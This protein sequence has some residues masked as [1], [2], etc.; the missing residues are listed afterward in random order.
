MHLWLCV[1][2]LAE[3]SS[4]PVALVAGQLVGLPR[5]VGQIK[6]GNDAKDDRGNAFEDE[7]PPPAA[8]SKPRYPQQIATEGRPHRKRKRMG[9]PKPPDAYRAMSGS[10]PVQ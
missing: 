7:Q 3:V 2:F 6:D 4:N 10:E 1:L 5:P 9:G 8:E